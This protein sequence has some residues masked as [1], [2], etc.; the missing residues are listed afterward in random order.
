[1]YQC[2]LFVQFLY[3]FQTIFILILNNQTK[4]TIDLELNALALID[5]YY[6]STF[7]LHDDTR[8][9]TVDRVSLIWCTCCMR[10][11]FEYDDTNIAITRSC[12]MQTYTLEL[13]CYITSILIGCHDKICDFKKP[14]IP[15]HIEMTSHLVKSNQVQIQVQVRWITVYCQPKITLKRRHCSR[16]VIIIILV[17]YLRTFVRF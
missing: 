5:T 12:L 14:F 16:I 9:T 7:H 13:L 10:L 8:I 6:A 1:M 17:L 4:H 11:S 2:N 3:L 15:S